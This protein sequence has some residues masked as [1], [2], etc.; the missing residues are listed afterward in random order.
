MSGSPWVDKSVRK[1]RIRHETE[2]EYHH[3]GVMAEESLRLQMVLVPAWI[4]LSR[5][6][7]PT[8]FWQDVRRFFT[9]SWRNV[10]KFFSNY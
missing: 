9:R 8:K 3:S 2:R 6:Y 1:H 5:R 4:C 7:G 10:C